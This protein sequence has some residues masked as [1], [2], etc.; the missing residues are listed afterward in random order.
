MSRTTKDLKSHKQ[1]FGKYGGKN[2]TR[3]LTPFIHD[4]NIIAGKNQVLMGQPENDLSQEGFT[5]GEHWH[6]AKTV[7]AKRKQVRAERDYITSQA[8][9]KIKQHDKKE[10]EDLLGN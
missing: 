9:A 10:I 2:P 1:G 6:N 8:R 3:K 7:R 5:N 4:A